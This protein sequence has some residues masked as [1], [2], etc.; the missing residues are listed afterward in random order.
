MALLMS[1][2]SWFRAWS[3]SST[4]VLVFGFAS[5]HVAGGRAR[6]LATTGKVRC[7][8]TY[9]GYFRYDWAPPFCFCERL[10]EGFCAGENEDPIL[11]AAAGPPRA[12]LRAARQRD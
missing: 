9:L 4:G 1:S 7:R 2:L 12:H 11:A 5:L 6:P 3:A 10:Q 8:L